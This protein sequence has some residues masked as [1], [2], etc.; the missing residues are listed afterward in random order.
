MKPHF[1]LTQKKAKLISSLETRIHD[2]KVIEAMARV[3]RHLFVPPDKLN[4]AYED[5][6]LPIGSGQ[7]ISQPYIVALMTS[8]LDLKGNETVLEVGTGSGYQAAILAELC[9]LV[10]TVERLPLM[11][12]K[13]AETLTSLGYTNIQVKTADNVLGWEENA[14]YDAILV[15]A[16][17][18]QI[19]QSLIKQLK[20]G[21]R[22]VIPV[23]DLYQQ[24]LF[25]IVK[26]PDD[27]DTVKLS[28]CRFVSLIGKEAWDEQ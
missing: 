1:N 5:T 22:M 11:A 3:P 26:H 24:E 21:G 10:I 4:L 13:A 25:K 20:T 14:P 7:T 18:P 19:P 27:I 16:A 23:G 2:K 9:K 12:A 15:A 17:A 6:P 8:A 28:G